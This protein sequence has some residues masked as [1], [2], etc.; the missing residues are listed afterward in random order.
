MVLQSFHNYNVTICFLRLIPKSGP[1]FAFYTYDIMNMFV[2]INIDLTEV[3]SQD[4]FR[5]VNQ[6][7]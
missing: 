4:K 6:K 1:I 2:Y 5:E 7:E 3:I